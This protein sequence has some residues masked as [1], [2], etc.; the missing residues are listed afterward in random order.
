MYFANRDEDA[1]TVNWLVKEESNKSDKRSGRKIACTGETMQDV[2]IELFPSLKV[3]SFQPQHTNRLDNRY[4][5]L[6]DFEFSGS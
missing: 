3:S 1:Q 6:A 5:C 4:M 2:V